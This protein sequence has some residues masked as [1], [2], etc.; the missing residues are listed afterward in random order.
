MTITRVSTSLVPASHLPPHTNIVGAPHTV[1]V[2]PR[3]TED[4][5]KIVKTAVKYRMPLTAFSGGT[6]LEGHYR[7]VRLY[8]HTSLYPPQE[9]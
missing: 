8:I 5:V 6:S 9:H 2:F 7:G 4:V 1:I 3:S